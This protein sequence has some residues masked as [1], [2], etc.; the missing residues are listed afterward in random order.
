MV[1]VMIIIKKELKGSTFWLGPFLGDRYHK[2]VLSFLTKKRRGGLGK[3]HETTLK[4]KKMRD[5]FHSGNAMPP[6]QTYTHTYTDLPL[7]R[8]GD[9]GVERKKVT[10]T[11]C[12][13]CW[14]RSL[15][16]GEAGFSASHC[17][18]SLGFIRTGESVPFLARICEHAR[19]V[20]RY[21]VVKRFFFFFLSSDL[22]SIA[23]F[24]FLFFKRRKTGKTVATPGAISGSSS[25]DSCLRSGGCLYGS[26]LNDG[27]APPRPSRVS[28][29]AD[30]CVVCVR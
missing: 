6:P 11:R 7:S 2:Q 3:R 28:L 21:F 22:S 18:C 5:A 17:T 1:L 10:N 19:R 26:G 13:S 25:R 15:E 29:L 20:H 9:E 12:S 23:S 16:M 24:F 30:V 8:N 4:K 27:A 14:L